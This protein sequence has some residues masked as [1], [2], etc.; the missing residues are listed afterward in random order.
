MGL[1]ADSSYGSNTIGLGMK[2]KYKLYEG[3][4]W[5]VSPYAAAAVNRYRQ[6]AYSEQGAG[7]YSQS[8]DAF[9]NTYSTGELGVEGRR[10]LRKGS[11]A[12]NVGYQKVLSG[13]DPQMTVAYS[14]NP[15]QKLSI[16]GAAQDREY[17]V[18]GLQAEDWVAPAWNISGQVNG[19]QGQHS[20]SWNASLMV[21][22]VW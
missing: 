14:G 3:R 8:A 10:T 11:Y 5:S 22:H 2:G 15:A 6:N 21:R 20:S 13:Y 9:T 12:V 1:T 18:W 16:S 19:E 17:L 4:Q 7:V